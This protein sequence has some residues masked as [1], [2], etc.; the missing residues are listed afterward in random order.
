M[1][2]MPEYAPLSS[3]FPR[4][5]F[6]SRAHDIGCAAGILEEQEMGRTQRGGVRDCSL[7]RV[8]ISPSGRIANEP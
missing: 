5:G 1:E 8:R 2:F 6:P 3:C 4:N 7:L